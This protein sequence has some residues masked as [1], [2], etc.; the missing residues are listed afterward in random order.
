MAE[1]QAGSE[2]LACSALTPLPPAWSWGSWLS[3]ASEPQGGREPPACSRAWQADRGVMDVPSAFVI[4]LPCFL[5]F[6][7]QS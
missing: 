4:Y 3:L 6:P 5:A 1:L 7:Q 2:V